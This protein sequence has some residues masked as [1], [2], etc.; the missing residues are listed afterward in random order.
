MVQVRSLG[1]VAP[2]YDISTVDG[3]HTVACDARK[4]DKLLER[5]R[6]RQFDD[7][8]KIEFMAI[9]SIENNTFFDVESY[10]VDIQLAEITMI[11][12]RDVK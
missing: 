7:T 11:Q 9:R 12:K 5:I 4:M 1:F 8:E 2:L 3:Q 10:N 6:R